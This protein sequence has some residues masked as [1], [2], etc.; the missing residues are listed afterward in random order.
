MKLIK[1]NIKHAVRLTTEFFYHFILIFFFCINGDGLIK[2][3]NYRF[4]I[5]ITKDNYLKCVQNIL[6]KY[7]QIGNTQ[8]LYMNIIVN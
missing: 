5:I 8:R 1:I 7:S 4:Y 2:L 6:Y 3:T